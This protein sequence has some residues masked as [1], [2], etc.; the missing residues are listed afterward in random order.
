MYTAKEKE[1]FAQKMRDN[2]TWPEAQ[3]W[4]ILST[5]KYGE[6][7][8]QVRLFGYIIDFYNAKRHIALEVDGSSHFDR[9]QEDKIRDEALAKKHIRTIRIT[10][11][12]VARN[13]EHIL[14]TVLGLEDSKRRSALKARGSGKFKVIK[15]GLGKGY[16]KRVEYHCKVL[17]Q[18]D[19][20]LQLQE[21]DSVCQSLFQRSLIVYLRYYLAKKLEA[22]D[23]HL[24]NELITRYQVSDEEVTKW[25]QV[26]AGG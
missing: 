15:K 20:P 24:M 17:D 9:I 25:R 13:C 14:S 4:K 6:W 2:P 23:Y 19:R 26:A 10:N 11:Q 7:N 5:G 1:A 3:V 16:R 8:T 18:L 21:L 22:E 12:Q